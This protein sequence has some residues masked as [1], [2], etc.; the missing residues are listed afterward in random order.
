[1]ITA[2][3][4]YYKDFACIA[5]ACRHSCCIGW[6]IDID[7]VSAEHYKKTEGALGEKMCRCIDFVSE[8]PHFILG[9]DERCP[10]LDGNNLCEIILTL[11]EDAISDICTD[12]PRFRTYLSERTEIGLGLCCEEAA[13]LILSQER[14]FALVEEG[15]GEYTMDEDCLMDLREEIFEI[16]DKSE[17]PVCKR[18]E[19]AL[20][21]C[22]GEIPEKSMG[23][24][25]RLYLGLERLDADWTVCLERL[26]KGS[27]DEKDIDSLINS[28]ER[29]FYNLFCYFIYRHLFSA[30]D[31]G[32]IGSKA[33]FACLSCRMLAALLLSHGEPAELETLVEYARMYSSE[34]EYSDENL[35]PIFESF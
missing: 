22:G 31:D 10:F 33:A 1:M 21:L 32:D 11:G 25:A 24:W 28:Q 19:A 23:D 7:P 27:W 18:M 29:W 13:R 4:D 17:M 3:P 15:D 30:L 9:E 35:E 12:H 16:M 5:S 20:E 14:S 6:E 2:Y 26:G 8:Q 34:I